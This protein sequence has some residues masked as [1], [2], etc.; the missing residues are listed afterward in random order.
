MP[1]KTRS[2]TPLEPAL[3]EA[4]PGGAASDVWLR[5]N[6][7]RDAADD[8]P[9]GG[10]VEFWEADEVHFVA[11]GVPEVADVKARI[12]ELWSAH[13]DDDL[14]GAERLAKLAQSVADQQAALLELGDLIGGEE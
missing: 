8:G 7:V 11:E 2:A 14:T 4:R 13:E 6:V 1:T 5:K 10:P 12:D 3:V 9:D